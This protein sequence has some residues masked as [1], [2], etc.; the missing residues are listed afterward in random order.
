MDK[1]I[2]K[3]IG[4]WFLI[5]ITLVGCYN[6]AHGTDNNGRDCPPGQEKKWV[7]HHW[8]CVPV[9]TT[10]TV[11]VE[12]TTTTSPSTTTVP[13]SSTVT[14]PDTTVPPVSTTGPTTTV[15]PPTDTAVPCEPVETPDCPT[16]TTYPCGHPRGCGTPTTVTNPPI[17]VD[18][19]TP[20]F[21]DPTSTL[22]TAGGSTTGSLPATGAGTTMLLVVAGLLMVFGAFVMWGVRR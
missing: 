10:T 8:K 2:R 18:I 9:A 3:L 6:T 15:G 13:P 14:I 20:A 19:G 5:L 4:G 11:S 16:P 1:M 7:N 17:T 12:T 22:S 21:S